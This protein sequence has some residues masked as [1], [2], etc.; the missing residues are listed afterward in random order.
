MFE[1]I[2]LVVCEEQAG[3]VLP[4]SMM[5]EFWWSGCLDAFANMCVLRCAEDSQ[6][7][8]RTVANSISHEMGQLYPESWAALMKTELFW[9]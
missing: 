7:E 2:K 4:L 1:E 9:F 6:Q 8:T 5:T 3:M